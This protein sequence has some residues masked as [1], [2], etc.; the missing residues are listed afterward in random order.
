MR[1]R[2]RVGAAPILAML[3]LLA[4][5]GCVE[6]LQ[7]GPHASLPPQRDPDFFATAVGYF[8][9]K[10]TVPILVDPRPL[11]P[12]AG[13]STVAESDLMS[14]AEQIVRMRARVVRS[15]GWRATSAPDD[16]RCVFSVTV[17]PAVARPEPRDTLQ[18]L[19]ERCRRRGPYESLVFGLPESGT[20]PDHPDRWRIRAMSMVPHGYEV[21]DLFLERTSAGAWTVSEARVRTGVF[22]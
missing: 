15:A 3:L 5:V 19:R 8:A 22:S 12:E 7:P 18:R 9:S 10:A 14:S 2:N 17:P 16:W 13:L 6:R 11:R 4:A 1:Y 21:V 20:D